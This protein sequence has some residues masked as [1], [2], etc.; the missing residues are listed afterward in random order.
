MDETHMRKL[1]N[2]IFTAP[3]RSTIKWSE[4]KLKATSNE[5]E[6]TQKLVA[7]FLQVISGGEPAN[8]LNDVLSPPSKDALPALNHLGDE[9]GEKRLSKLNSLIQKSQ[10]L[11]PWNHYNG[12][13]RKIAL[14]IE[15]TA[16]RALSYL[17]GGQIVSMLDDVLYPN[18]KEIFCF[19]YRQAITRLGE[20]VKL[21]HPKAKGL[22]MNTLKQS[23]FSLD[24]LK[25]MNWSFSN[26]LWDV[27]SHT[28]R[29]FQT[30]N[31][32]PNIHRKSRSR[33]LTT[34]TFSSRSSD[35]SH[36]P[37][38]RRLRRSRSKPISSKSSSIHPFAISSSQGRQFMTDSLFAR[39]NLRPS[40]QYLSD[41]DT[42]S[43]DVS[44]IR[45]PMFPQLL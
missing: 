15:L 6:S 43:D 23:G 13:N 44:N 3:K 4:F 33:T 8:L 26:H 45:N 36:I 14:E 11:K 31:L 16:R 37:L 38:K 20:T 2:I 25:A 1:K 24:D 30:M 18:E 7:E 19:K 41:S 29:G 9:M 27:G 39:E 12:G 42:H 5:I 32:R 35:G 21:I 40:S 17:S 22:V 28:Q 10:P 34:T